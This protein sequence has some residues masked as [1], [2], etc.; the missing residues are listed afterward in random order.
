MKYLILT[1]IL[2]LLCNQTT[3]QCKDDNSSSVSDDLRYEFSD[4]IVK[5]EVIV[6]FK[7]FYTVEARKNYISGSTSCPAMRIEKSNTMMKVLKF[8]ML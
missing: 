5:S 4:E 8:K 7:G 3:G 2:T 1:F 6:K